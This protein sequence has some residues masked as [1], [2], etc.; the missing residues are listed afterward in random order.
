MYMTSVQL[1]LSVWARE[2]VWTGP[3]W[4]DSEQWKSK[5]HA[6]RVVRSLI[7]RRVGIDCEFVEGYVMFNFWLKNLRIEDRLLDP[8]M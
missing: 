1:V 4:E 7:L 5:R 3:R 8:S 6:E 2:L